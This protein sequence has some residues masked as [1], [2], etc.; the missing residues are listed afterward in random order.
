MCQ[1]LPWDGVHEIMSI[2]GFD[3]FPLVVGFIGS[4]HCLGMCGVLVFACTV[5]CGADCERGSRARRPTFSTRLLLPHLLFHLGRLTTYATAGAIAAGF[6][7]GLQMTAIFQVSYSRL[8]LVCGILLLVLALAMAR[9]IPIP[10]IADRAI[11]ASASV[12][13]SWA[14]SL[15]RSPAPGKKFL[16][17]LLTGMLPCCLSW[18]MVVTAAA[19]HGPL[20]GF[21]AMLWFGIGTTPA[22]LAAALFGVAVSSRVREAGE[23]LAALSLG[24]MGITLILRGVG[25]LG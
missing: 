22:L 1:T 8:T 25:I 23:K 9:M 15:I 5:D 19:T 3:L 11:A 20:E 18:S 7:T 6:T 10:G 4:L 17:G 21:W 14:P 16:L 2:G 13:V 24:V 12:V